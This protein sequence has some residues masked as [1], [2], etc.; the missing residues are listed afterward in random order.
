MFIQIDVLGIT[1]AD[2]ANRDAGDILEVNQFGSS[3]FKLG[4]RKIEEPL[5]TLMNT[6][7]MNVR[8]SIT[9]KRKLTLYLMQGP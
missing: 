1:G 5:K 2:S 8:K 4:S 7:D 6:S 3:R 9:M